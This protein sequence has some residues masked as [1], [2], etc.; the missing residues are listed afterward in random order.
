[1][2]R[3]SRPIALTLDPAG[4]FASDPRYWLWFSAAVCPPHINDIATS[5]LLCAYA[6]VISLF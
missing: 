1:M 6:A 4:G 3:Y 2:S 5:Q